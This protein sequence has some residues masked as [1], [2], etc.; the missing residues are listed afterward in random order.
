MFLLVHTQK[1]Q[2]CWSS[3]RGP[4]HSHQLKLARQLEVLQKLHRNWRDTRG[5][6]GIQPRVMLKGFSTICFLQGFIMLW[7]VTRDYEPRIP[8]ITT[9][10]A[11]IVGVC[12]PGTVHWT[13][14][15]MSRFT[16]HCPTA[17]LC[18]CYG[19]FVLF[20][21]FQYMGN[22]RAP[23]SF[24]TDSFPKLNMRWSRHWHR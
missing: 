4:N 16:V 15:G 23:C 12:R 8:M 18:V 5:G 19:C 7:V 2:I 21:Y 9:I 20:P 10:K 11:A 24:P 3:S 17:S 22:H 6:M 13:T 14:W 1:H